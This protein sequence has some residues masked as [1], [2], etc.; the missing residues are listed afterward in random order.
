MQFTSEINRVLIGMLIV[1]G[2]IAAAAFYWTVAGPDSLLN[3]EDNPR[4]VE[5]EAAIMRGD[6]RDRRDR[7]L[8]ESVQRDDS[9]YRVYNFPE[10]YSA[11]G[12]FSLRYGVGGAEAAYNTILRGD[13]LPEDITQTL[14][15][16]PQV[17]SDIQVTFNLEVQEEVFAVMD[18]QQGAAV[19]LS[20][21]RGE[22]IAM[23]SLPTYDPNI[24]DDEWDNLLTAPGNPFFNRVLQGQYQPGGTL[25]LPLIALAFLNNIPR[26]TLIEDAAQ[27]VTLNGVTL[28][29][30]IPAPDDDLTLTQAF[31][32]GCPYPFAQ[33]TEN[34]GMN[35]VDMT[36]T[37]FVLDTQPTIPGFIAEPDEAVEATAEPDATETP[38][39]PVTPV[40]RVLGQGQLTINPLNMALI[41]AAIINGGN[42]PQPYALQATR[43]PDAEDWSPNITT[44]SSL[45]FM[46][47]QVAT[48]MQGL[49]RESAQMGTAQ[50]AAQDGLNIGGHAALA[51]SGEG[52]Q[53]W[54]VGYVLMDDG[55]GY[56]TAVV[57][58][59]SDDI[60]LAARIG[61]TALAAAAHAHQSPVSE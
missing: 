45:P 28:T 36:F 47:T 11:L 23:V 39:V 27:P 37:T 20:V 29:C 46:T 52:T 61:G 32:Y 13:D 31:I 34:P 9:L 30:T 50:A 42:A 10:M 6:I 51:Y 21:P 18:G 15:H 41:A 56:A 49:M 16:Q 54:F 2:M 7:V 1:F 44:R 17:G 4:L 48:M 22:V 8:V 3:R 12:Y 43:S 60:A 5:A 58:E 40:E 38:I 33:M 14:L 35:A 24:L 57:L 55:T 53:A 26:D 25:Q 59:N 19:V